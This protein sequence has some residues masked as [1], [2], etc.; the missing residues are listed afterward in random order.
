MTELDLT[1]Y[2][3]DLVSFGKIKVQIYNGLEESKAL[4]SPQ[5]SNL[6]TF[7]F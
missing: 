5:V 6:L 2:L 3:L 1:K 7:F 4:D